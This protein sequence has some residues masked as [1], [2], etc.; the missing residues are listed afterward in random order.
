[1]EKNLVVNIVGLIIGI[2]CGVDKIMI[3]GM[4][5]IKLK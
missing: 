5:Y 3:V 2:V 1:M 4:Y